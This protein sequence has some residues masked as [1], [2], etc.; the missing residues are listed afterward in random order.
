MNSAILFKQAQLFQRS[1]RCQLT[2]NWYVSHILVNVAMKGC[3][4]QQ[5]NAVVELAQRI[6]RAVAPLPLYETEVVPVKLT[7]SGSPPS[8]LSVLLPILLRHRDTHLS[9]V[10]LSASFQCAI[11]EERASLSSFIVYLH[12][13][14]APLCC[15]CMSCLPGWCKGHSFPKSASSLLRLC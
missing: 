6:D 5:H 2:R 11:K 12:S 9:L 14:A 7:A 10:F 1:P 15:G 13:S 3:P 4:R 8:L